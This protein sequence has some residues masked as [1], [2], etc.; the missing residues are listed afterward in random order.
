MNQLNITATIVAALLAFLAIVGA[1]SYAMQQ[2]R[3][4]LT[5]CITLT[6]SPSECRL[7]VS[8]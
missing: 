3:L 8:G 7:A 1:A 4:N 6:H 5:R 2:D